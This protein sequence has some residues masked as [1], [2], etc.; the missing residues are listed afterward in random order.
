[1]LGQLGLTEDEIR[2]IMGI[3]KL[4]FEA[5]KRSERFQEALK[6]G[7]LKADL[8]VIS[9]LYDKA[10]QGDTVAMI[11]WLKNRLPGRWRDKQLV[12]HEGV[13][14]VV[15][16]AFM[17]KLKAGRR[18]EDSGKKEGVNAEVE[19]GGREERAGEEGEGERVN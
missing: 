12:E 15:S 9:R 13:T 1:M 5:W 17:P 6:K 16:E 2:M 8:Q 19:G 4:R 10:V 3:P 11:F 14:Y 18:A 7:K